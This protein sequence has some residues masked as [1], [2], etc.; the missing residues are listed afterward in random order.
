[1]C[2]MILRIHIFTHRFHL[3]NDKEG[4]TKKTAI[5]VWVYCPGTPTDNMDT[6]ASKTKQKL[7]EQCL[8]RAG[9][10]FALYRLQENK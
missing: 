6:E 9:T 3:S 10:P 2:Q 5:H 4:L 8:F 7:T 1:M